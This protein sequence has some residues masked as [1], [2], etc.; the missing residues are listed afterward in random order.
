MSLRIADREKRRGLPPALLPLRKTVPG[1][2]GTQVLTALS[3]N[4]YLIG[5]DAGPGAQAPMDNYTLS[6][7]L[8]NISLSCTFFA[9]TAGGYSA[10]FVAD[11]LAADAAKP[12]AEFDNVI[13]MLDWLN[14]E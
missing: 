8:A 9:G 10:D 13:D 11:L 1:F 12:E 7:A 6:N 2:S 5:L 3:Q 14:R 4:I